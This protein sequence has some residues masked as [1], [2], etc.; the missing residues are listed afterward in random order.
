[1]LIIA[2][3]T[4]LGRLW[5]QPFFEML[6]RVSLRGMYYNQRQ[7]IKKSGEIHA[8]IYANQKSLNKDK[9]IFD[10]GANT[11]EWTQIALKV[12]PGAKFHIFEP[13]LSL[14]KSLKK[15]S[16]NENVIINQF[17]I[18]N[19]KGN[20]KLYNSG[21]LIASSY[22]LNKTSTFEE[23][24]VKTIESYCTENGIE[25]IFYLKI[26]VEGN[27]FKVLEG[28]A[29]LLNKN[30]VKFIQFEFGPNHVVS[31]NFLKD[32]FVILK[33]YKIHRIVRGGLRE[34]LYN[35]INEILLTVNYLAE[36]IPEKNQQ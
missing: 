14:N 1:M 31:G 7:H 9:I 2:E 15:F 10:V 25:N 18:S 13:S 28:C 32:F 20:M 36:L 22:P 19:D 34:I 23:I 11:G 16:N 33:N 24:K 12:F 21:E 8:M 3:E 5:L 26:D 29:E 35:E 4:F 27:E 17:G 30:K 6:H